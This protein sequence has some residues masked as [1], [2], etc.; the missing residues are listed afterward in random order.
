MRRPEFARGAPDRAITALTSWPAFAQAALTEA[1]TGDGG[2]GVL[3]LVRLVDHDQIVGRQQGSAQQVQHEQVGVDDH[4]VGALG[5][6]P[7]GFGEAGPALGA[8]GSA[9]TLLG[10]DAQALPQSRREFPS[11]RRPG[12]RWWP[13]RPRRAAGPDPRCRRRRAG[14]PLPAP[15]GGSR[16]SFA[17]PP[18][19]SSSWSPLRV[20]SATSWRQM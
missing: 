3:E 4:D 11:P 16:G 14:P 18:T 10:G 20:A 2:D 7:G 5:A 6:L 19:A 15:P 13:G 8:A 1:H 9:G 12:R 17:S